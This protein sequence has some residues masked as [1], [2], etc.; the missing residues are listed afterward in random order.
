M[1]FFIYARGLGIQSADLYIERKSALK[2]NIYCWSTLCLY[3]GASKNKVMLV[4]F[5]W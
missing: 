4:Y 2:T 1:Q 5:I 3:F